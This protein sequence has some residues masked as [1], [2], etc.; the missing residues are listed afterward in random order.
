MADVQLSLFSRVPPSGQ[1]KP[2][3]P[4]KGGAKRAILGGGFLALP[5]EKWALGENNLVVLLQHFFPL[6][7]LDGEP[8]C[9]PAELG[10]CKWT[11]QRRLSQM[12]ITHSI[13][14]LVLASPPPQPHVEACRSIVL[15][16]VHRSCLLSVKSAHDPSLGP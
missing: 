9:R 5:R 14:G 10:C 3:L 6:N 8:S 16:F 11:K 1:H 7:L 13:S 4:G 12:D 15:V 2:P